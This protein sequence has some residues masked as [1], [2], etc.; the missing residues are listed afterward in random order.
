MTTKE[1]LHELVDGLSEAEADA[2]LEFVV[3]REHSGDAEMLPLP[4]SWLTL[5]SGQ[6]APNW[7]AGLDEV[8]SGR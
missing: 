6:P 8:R 1:R 4:T 2:T 3:S 7:V 5:P